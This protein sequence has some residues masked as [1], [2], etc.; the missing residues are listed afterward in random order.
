MFEFTVIAATIFITASLN[1]ISTTISW[2]R[3]KSRI[4]LYFAIGM[5]GVTFWT[6]AS[7]FDYAAVPISLKIYFAKW[8]Y[9]VYHIALIF[10][11]MFI[12]SF[13]G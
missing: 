9:V 3:V 13:A 5:T 6:L 4:G 10:F 12:M 1:V 2:R 7:G 8:E 11:L